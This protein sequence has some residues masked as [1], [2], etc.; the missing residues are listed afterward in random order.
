M[1]KL[2][3]KIS[4]LIRSLYF[5][6]H[7]LPF[8]QAIKLPILL[9]NVNLEDIRGKVLIEYDNVYR[10][11]IKIGVYGVKIFPKNKTVWQNQGG[12]VVFKGSCQIG[13]S[14]AISVES[15]AQLIFGDDFINSYGLRLI[16]SR[17]IHFGKT[18]RMGWNVL[19]MDTNMHPLVNKE[20]GKRGGG[21]APISIGDYNWFST[22]CVVLPGVNTPERIICGLGSVVTRNVEWEPYCMYGGSPIHRIRSNVYRDFENDKDTFVYNKQ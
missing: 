18:N 17:K 13:A 9:Y 4:V 14:S 11:M 19:I 16:V 15:N 10:G 2:I 20:T 12:V 7:Y 6:I 22:N 3:N 21:G 1:V 8:K 5:C